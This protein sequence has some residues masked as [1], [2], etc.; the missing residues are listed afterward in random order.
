M[1]NLLHRYAMRHIVSKEIFYTLYA[2]EEEIT[3]ANFN[4]FRSHEQAR[5]VLVEAQPIPL[6]AARA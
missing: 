3:K 6:P 4:L 2:T 5:F 1:T